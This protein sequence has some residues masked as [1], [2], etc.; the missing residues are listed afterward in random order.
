[1]STA[2]QNPE[3]REKREEREEQEKR[4]EQDGPVK[5]TVIQDGVTCPGKAPWSLTASRLAA[6]SM[7]PTI[8]LGIYILAQT[9]I[10]KLLLWLLILV[11]FIYPLRYLIC[12]RCPYY[13]QD[14][15]TP[16][17]KIVPHLF[18]KQEG[19][20]MLL[21]L[22]LDLV[23]LAVLFVLPLPEVWKLG[24]FLL[25]LVWFGAQTFTSAVLTRMACSVCPLTFCPVG[26]MGRAI[27]MRGEAK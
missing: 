9:N 21:G 1:M 4:E 15:S 10:P 7:V 12:A 18:K 16:F 25:L 17:G 13:G 22:W 3:K 8:V 14:C 20:S 24:G 19:K 27:W 6:L 23:F 26:R 5:D 2:H 11:V